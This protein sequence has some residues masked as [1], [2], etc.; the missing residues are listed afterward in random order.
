MAIH[1][2]WCMEMNAVLQMSVKCSTSWKNETTMHFVNNSCKPEPNLIKFC[3]WRVTS[4]S[5]NTKWFQ[6]SVLLRCQNFIDVT[7]MLL[8]IRQ[9]KQSDCINQMFKCRISHS[10]SLHSYVCSYHVLLVIVAL[11]NRADHYI[12]APWFLSIFFF[13]RLISVV[14]DWMSTILPQMVWP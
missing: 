4:I 1:H 6:T 12:F 11:C 7:Q 13:P 14:G 10:Y 2:L 3:L 9:S 8:F 5:N